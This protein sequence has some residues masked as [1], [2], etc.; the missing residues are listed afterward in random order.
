MVSI[1][2]REIISVIKAFTILLSF[3]ILISSFVR[4]SYNG[5]IFDVE[6][7]G[8][9]EVDIM[10]ISI[11]GMLN[12]VV[13]RSFHN[14]RQ[15]EYTLSKHFQ[16]DS[17]MFLYPSL[18]N[19]VARLCPRPRL[20]GRQAVAPSVP[21]LVGAQ[22]LKFLHRGFKALNILCIIDCIIE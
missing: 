9:Y 2:T 4:V 3:N 19:V 12:R 20:G 17:T 7:T 18:C 10:S 15:E 5:V 14:N 1:E 21:A 22:V 6:S 8:P 13:T 11:A 16:N